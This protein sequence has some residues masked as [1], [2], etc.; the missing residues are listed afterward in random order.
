MPASTAL[1]TALATHIDTLVT[2]VGLVNAGGVE[3]AGGGYARQPVDWV[4]DGTTARPSVDESFSI[5]AGDT[6]G[7]WR[8]YSALAAGT[9]YGGDD[10]PNETYAGA[11]TYTLLAASTG[12]PVTAAP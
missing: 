5:E 11:G 6:V 8:G 10:L 4:L 3:L 7:G 9:D 2:H 12:Y 1:L